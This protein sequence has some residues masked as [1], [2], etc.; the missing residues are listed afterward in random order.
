MTEPIV[1]F[2][3]RRLDVYLDDLRTLVGIDSG[4]YDKAGVDKINDWLEE[5][6]RALGFSV[7][8]YPQTESGDD[9]LAT[10]RGKGQ[11]RILLLGHSDTVFPVGTAGERPMTIQGDKVLGPGTCDMKAGLLT[12][13][14]ALEAL[15]EIGFDGYDSISYLCVTDE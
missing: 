15:R 5:R 1:T 6:L 13:I 3:E 12:G 10:Q 11:G 2:L 7:E 4:S 9:L 14:Y 8:R